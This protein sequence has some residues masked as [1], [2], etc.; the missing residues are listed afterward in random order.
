MSLHELLEGLLGLIA[1][2]GL[3]SLIK[4]FWHVTLV[5]G[6]S[7]LALGAILILTPGYL[8]TDL[9]CRPALPKNIVICDFWELIRVH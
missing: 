8:S 1:F 7:L 6:L 4:N 2:I 5:I 9:T 3:V